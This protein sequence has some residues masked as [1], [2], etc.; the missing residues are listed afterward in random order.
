VQNYEGINL[1]LLLTGAV[2]H[3]I[4]KTQ[5][6]A[7]TRSFS[8]TNEGQLLGHMILELEIV[9]GKIAQI[10]D[11]PREL[12]TLIQHLII[13]HHGE[14]EFG[15]PKLPM[16][17]EALILHCLDNL[18]SKVEAMQMILR[19]DPNVEG[20][21]TSYNTMFGRPLFKG[22][23]DMAKTP[24]RRLRFCPTLPGLVRDS[25]KDCRN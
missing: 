23:N 20:S 25:A 8:Y 11:F 12:K 3:D 1:D 2:V 7:Y 19:A 5:E 13:S 24:E 10:E 22:S 4:G 9:N 15:S 21:W 16:F 6:L 18:D 17:P 14:Y